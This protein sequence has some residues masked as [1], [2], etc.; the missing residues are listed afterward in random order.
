MVEVH[1]RREQTNEDSSLHEEREWNTNKEREKDEAHQVLTKQNLISR[2]VYNLL[3]SC[4]LRTADI[5]KQYIHE[6][7]NVAIE[8]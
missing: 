6:R 3:K 5:T 7:A 1:K 4:F 8:F 2:K